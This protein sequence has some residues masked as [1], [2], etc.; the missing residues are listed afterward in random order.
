MS[1]ENDRS[2]LKTIDRALQ[3]LLAFTE[4]KPE[5]GV[6]ELS[7]HFG[8]EKSVVQRMLSTLQE[9]DFVS[10]NPET[11]KYRLGFALLSLGK[12]VSSQL[13]MKEIALE[14]MHR[15]AQQTGESIILTV[16]HHRESVC[17]EVVEGPSKIRYSDTTGSRTPMHVGAG[18][19]V[20]FSF[21][22][23]E[24]LQ[25]LA[26]DYEFT[27]FT[28]TSPDRDGFFREVAEIRRRGV[29][30]SM[31]EID[32]G[33]AAVAVPVWKRNEVIAGLC[34]IGPIGRVANDLERIERIMIATGRELSEK[35]TRYSL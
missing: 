24:E 4:Q 33:V 11:R 8:W 13:D 31:E 7:R 6:T 2:I 32:P 14:F 5:W 29:A 12:L 19:K 20:L 15:L 34:L 30:V 17:I 35:L 10:Q 28:P 22:S 9:R 18:S 23:D 25:A 3:L 16:P 21:K 26:K 1:P 27:K